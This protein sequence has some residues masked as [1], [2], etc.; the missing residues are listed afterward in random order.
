[1]TVAGAEQVRRVFG[2]TNRL[3]GLYGAVAVE[4]PLYAGSVD[5]LCVSRNNRHTYTLVGGCIRC[6]SE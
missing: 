4:E 5:S 3:G 6:D 1:M 2:K